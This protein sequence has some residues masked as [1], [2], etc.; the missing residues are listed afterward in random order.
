MVRVPQAPVNIARGAVNV[1][2]NA[3][4]SINASNLG[5]EGIKISFNGD[6]SDA[7]DLATSITMVQR[8]YQTAVATISISKAN[9]L[10]EMWRN[11]LQSNSDIGDV[12]I[13][14]DVS[15]RSDYVLYRCHIKSIEAG[16]ISNGDVT[17][18]IVIHGE[19][20]INEA[21]FGGV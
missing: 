4:L 14:A 11:Q 20:R 17:D 3:N 2:S 5:K 15:L 1:L 16:G 10:A 9:S 8:P 21:L 7:V 18:S 6:A 12:Y 13:R 19:Y